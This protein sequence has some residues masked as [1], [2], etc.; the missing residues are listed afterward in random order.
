MIIFVNILLDHGIITAQ[1]FTALL[2][3]AVGS[4]MLTIPM[5]APR[6]FRLQASAQYRSD[7]SLTAYLG[8]SEQTH[9]QKAALSSKT[10]GSLAVK[11]L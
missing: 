4:T 11:E 6:W 3:M 8:A 5:V 1:T 9:D 2:F 10:N 7:E